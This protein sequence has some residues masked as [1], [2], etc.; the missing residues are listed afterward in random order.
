MSYASSSP[1]DRLAD[2]NWRIRHS[3]WMLALFLG[4]GILSFIGFLYCAIRVRSKKWWRIAAITGALSAVG[5][6][7]MGLFA[8]TEEGQESTNAPGPWDDIAVG[9]IIVLWIGLMVYGFVAN[10]DYLRWRASSTGASAWYNQSAGAASATNLAPAPT[11]PVAYSAPVAPTPLLDVDSSPYF[12]P[13]APSV[14]PAAASGPVDVNSADVA[15]I[16]F[17]VGMDTSTAERI[18]SA[19]EQRRGFQSIDDLVASAGLQPHELMKLRGKIVFGQ[20]SPSTQPAANTVQQPTPPHDPRSGRIL[21][22]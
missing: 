17:A 11:E 20:Y 2:K 19:R 4:F 7:L 21:D 6:L 10:R 16:A 3:A 15:T 18:V 22:Y 14:P 8:E 1:S 13:T 5:W 12:A 9:Y